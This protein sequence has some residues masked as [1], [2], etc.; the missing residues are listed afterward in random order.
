MVTGAPHGS[1]QQNSPDQFALALPGMVAGAP[2]GSMQQNS[3]DQFA[4]ALPGMNNAD[5]Y[6]VALPRMAAGAPHGLMQQNNHDQI[7]QAVP[8]FNDQLQIAVARR[9]AKM[10]EWNECNNQI[11]GAQQNILSMQNEIKFNLPG[12][13]ASWKFDKSPYGMRVVQ[14]LTN[15]KNDL[16]H[17]LKNMTAALPVLRKNM[18][19]KA[20]E[21][22]QLHNVAVSM[23]MQQRPATV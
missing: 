1:M 20:N 3:P 5:Q 6:A 12:Q 2:H 16:E 21:I 9:E 18:E 13:I 8:G 22:R 15:T 19:T 17:N 23:S 10:R 7:P 14:E 4:L 11:K